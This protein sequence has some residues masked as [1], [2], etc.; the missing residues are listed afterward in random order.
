[1]RVTVHVYVY[2]CVSEMEFIVALIMDRRDVPGWA[3]HTFTL[4]AVI[5]F[6]DIYLSKMKT[7]VLIKIHKYVHHCFGDGNPKLEIF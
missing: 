6:L 2:M 4:E 1:M 3:G 7:Y 5:L